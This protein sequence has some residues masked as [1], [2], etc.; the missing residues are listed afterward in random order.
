MTDGGRNRFPETC[1]DCGS[2]FKVLK[3]RGPDEG[4]FDWRFCPN[5]GASLGPDYSCTSG[6][7]G[8]R[9]E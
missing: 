8:D 6:E 5:C 7:D 9:D 4:S 1:D 2:R 3:K